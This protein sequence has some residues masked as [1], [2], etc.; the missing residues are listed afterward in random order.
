MR[1]SIN[2]ATLLAAAM[3]CGSAFF[4]PAAAQDTPPETTQSEAPKTETPQVEISQIEI[5]E[6]Q[7]WQ[8]E[9]PQIGT[10]QIET[11][12]ELGSSFIDSVKVTDNGSTL[13]LD[14]VKT[15]DLGLRAERE[16]ARRENISLSGALSAQASFGEGELSPDLAPDLTGLTQTEDAEFRRLGAYA[17]V[18]AR[19]EGDKDTDWTPFVSAGLGVAQD[20][21]TRDTQVFEDLSPVGRYRAGLEKKVSDRVT[22]GASVGQTFKLD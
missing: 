1:K 22:F 19:L 6:I 7:D 8:L 14:N 5:S 3:F 21:V 18:I 16:L 10:G 20:R 12:L 15:L 13:V 17:D 11:S 2:P 9:T 4:G